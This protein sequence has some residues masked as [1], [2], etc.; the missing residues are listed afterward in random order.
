MAGKSKG[1]TGSRIIKILFIFLNLIFVIAL[2]LSYAAP[3][4]SPETNSY[5]PFFG[6]GYSILVMIN[7]CFVVIWIFFNWRW[8]LLSILTIALG[9]NHIVSHIQYRSEHSYTAEEFPVKILSYNVRNFDIYNYDKNWK[10]N[11]EKRDKILSLI[12]NNQPDILCFQEYVHDVNNDF[13]TTD[14]LIKMLQ[15]VFTDT[16]FNIVSRNII[17]FGLA[18]FSKY[19][20]AGHGQI[21]FDNSSANFCI[22]TDLVIRQDTVRVYNAHFESIRLS[23]KDI[24]YTHE[25]T[26]TTDL[27]K[28]KKSSKRIFSLLR[29]AF[30]DRASQSEKVAEHVASCK[31]PVIL[32]TDLN[33]TPASYAYRRLNNVLNDAFTAAGTG[34]GN[35]YA[36]IFPP[37]RI[38]FIMYSKHFNAYNFETFKVDYSDHYPISCEMTRK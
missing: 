37:I 6:L 30:I 11:I 22:Y 31:Y 12:K 35:T 13:S 20:I 27:D 32:C 17:K 9:W 16:V 23:K 36:G 7:L 2:G 33:D 38:D 5:L 29:A 34:F 25:V 4:V 26:E 15:P 21:A 10:S 18:T 14:T 8:A 1:S 3:Y 28:H 24:E 19:P